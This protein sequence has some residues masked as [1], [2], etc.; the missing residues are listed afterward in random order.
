MTRAAFVISIGLIVQNYLLWR[1]LGSFCGDGDGAEDDVSC[2]LPVRLGEA[3]AR[4]VT[5]R[6]VRRRPF[7]PVGRQD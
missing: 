5:F 7:G 4:A 3:K 6:S 2:G 1:K